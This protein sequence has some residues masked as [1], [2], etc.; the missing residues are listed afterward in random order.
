MSSPEPVCSDVQSCAWLRV[1]GSTSERFSSDRLQLWF[2]TDVTACMHTSVRRLAVQSLI[3]LCLSEG[4]PSVCYILRYSVYAVHVRRRERQLDQ[5]P[6]V[7]VVAAR[8]T[9]C[10]KHCIFFS[11]A[12][13]L[14]TWNYSPQTTKHK[15]TKCT[16]K[17]KC[18]SLLDQR[19]M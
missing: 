8:L 14:V 13:S 18:A 10:W 12:L 4:K 9:P 16:N 3:S 6:L 17:R 5:L 2:G 1:R 7:D 11:F 15:C 19:N